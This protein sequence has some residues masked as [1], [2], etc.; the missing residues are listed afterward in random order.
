MSLIK[1]IPRYLAA[2]PVCFATAVSAAESFQI[3]KPDPMPGSGG[4]SLYG[5]ADAGIQYS[6]AGSNRL[7]QSESGA[8][9]TSRFGLLGVEH[10]GNGLSVSFNLESA[11]KLKNGSAGGTT[12][13]GESSLFN[14]EANISLISTQWG[15]IKLGRQYPTELSIAIDPF[16]G[17]GAFSPLAS[18]VSLSSDL[19]KGATIG[20]SRISDAISYSTPILG[21]FQ[22]E[23]LHAPRGVTTPG[24]PKSSFHGAQLEYASGPLYLGMFYNIINTDPTATVSSVRN[25][26][27]GAGGMYSFPGGTNATY[28]FNMTNPDRAGYFIATSHMVGLSV[29]TGPGVI[30]FSAVYRNVAGKASGDSLA[31]GLGY[32]YNMSKTTALYARLG[33]VLNQKN[34]IGSLAGVAL[35]QPGDDVSIVATGIRMRF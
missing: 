9:A 31:I 27:L 33:Y 13:E 22:F 6:R 35:S 25:R 23:Y 5:V 20:D 17:V 8:G 1:Q 34:A 16:L 15:R 7:L 12:A 19:G 32:D 10:L 29:P 24:Y 26:W 11:L 4:L 21:G 30:K 18:L 2:F 28:E 3:L 14:R